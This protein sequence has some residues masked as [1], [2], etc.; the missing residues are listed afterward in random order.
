MKPQHSFSNLGE[1]IQRNPSAFIVQAF[2]KIL[3]ARRLLFISSFIFLNIIGILILR[4]STSIYK[5]QASLLMKDDTKGSDWG[6][7]MLW[8]G[9][10]LSIG[11]NNVD[12]EIEILKSRTLMRN[13]ILDLQLYIHYFATGHVK[14]T[15]IYAESPFHLQ[16]L[17]TH[18]PHMP[19]KQALFEIRPISATQY[20]LSNSHNTWE[21]VFGD[22]LSLSFG[23][24]LITR[25]KFPFVPENIYSFQFA[26]LDDE[27]KRYKK[28]LSVS[29]NNKFVSMVQLYFMDIIPLRGERILNKH[30][31][32]YLQSNVDDKN[33]IIDSALIFIDENIA[34]VSNE[35]TALETEIEAYRKRNQLSDLSET[36]RVLI[37]NTSINDQEL[38]KLQTQIKITHDLKLHLKQFPDRII[39]AT[40]NI[41]GQNFSS[42]L[43]KYNDLQSYQ[44]KLL[45]ALTVSHPDVQNTKLEML[46]IRNDLLE[47]IDTKLRALET[48]YTETQKTADQIRL[49]LKDLPVKARQLL[50]Y[51]R[52]QQ[53]KQ[54][55]YLILLKKRIE[56]SFS[57]STNLPNGRIIDYAQADQV[58]F[59]P[60]KKVVL[61]LSSMLG[62]TTPFLLIYLQHIFNTKVRSESQFSAILRDQIIGYVQTGAQSKGVYEH[63][64]SSHES[65]RKL[66][67]QIIQKLKKIDQIILITAQTDDV[68]KTYIANQIASSLSVLPKKTL[69]IRLDKPHNHLVKS[70]LKNT[71]DSHIELSDRIQQSAEFRN[72]NYLNMPAY[73][74]DHSDCWLDTTLQTLFQYLRQK[75]DYIVIDCTPTGQ[76]SDAFILASHVQFT[77]FVIKY[78]VTEI[79]EL[80]KIEQ[81]IRKNDLPN[82]HFIVNQSTPKSYQFPL[83]I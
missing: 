62:I 48:Q 72:L 41:E 82:C 30:M 21:G 34:K 80:P 50:G 58:P 74:M 38:A 63:S 40:L 77:L 57:K 71:S 5:M 11:K 20:T 22:T 4:Y 2:L 76:S 27:I 36:S 10:G 55:L 43:H 68:D 51:D 66:R 13:V 31:E 47:S 56:T 54:D 42:L 14:T 64:D 19:S 65:F 16:Y 33:Q 78:Q 49:N 9:L 25:T 17:S 59:S 53:I 6:E 44:N 35:L 7:S 24:I 28:A 73:Q 81:I 45:I 83:Q 52:Q 1:T 79:E 67:T 46:S 69:L 3:H 29:T 39:P 37:Q 23:N 15:E 60:N 70:G 61:F 12:N 32:N 75:Y 18:A 8:Q 26:T